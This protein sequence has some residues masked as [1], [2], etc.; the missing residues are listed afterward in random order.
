MNR[1]LEEMHRE[2]KDNPVAVLEELMAELK[3]RQRML[4]ANAIE[5]KA[6]V[7]VP[8]NPH[9]ILPETITIELRWHRSVGKGLSRLCGA[10]SP[11]FWDMELQLLSRSALKER[12]ENW[13]VRVLE[14]I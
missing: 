3:W 14:R 11:I 12:M 5:P 13:F 10:N 6:Y 9:L 8:K 1:I 4:E 2:V 7:R